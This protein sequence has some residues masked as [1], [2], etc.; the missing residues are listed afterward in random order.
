MFIAGTETASTVMEWAM[1]ELMRNPKVMEN[2]QAE[3]REVLKGKAPIEEKDIQEL[4]Y[5]KLVIKETLRLHTPLPLLLP[6][7]CR[8]RCEIDGYEIPAKTRV[9]INAWAIGRDPQ[10]WDDAESFRPERFIGTSIDFKG[11]DFELIPFGAGRRMCPGMSFGVAT[12]ELA[13]AQ[14]LYYFEW[15]L[16]NAIEPEDL[17]MTEAFGVAMGRKSNLYL[18]PF[19]HLPS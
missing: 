7:E 3:V 11:A 18:I 13:L 17:D 14:L 16:P 10:Q 2:A 6:R 4:N 19:S 5:L 9:I 1:A 12:V 8:E 15:K